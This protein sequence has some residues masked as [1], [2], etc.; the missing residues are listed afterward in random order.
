[1]WQNHRFLIGLIVGSISINLSELLWSQSQLLEQFVPWDNFDTPTQD[2][3]RGNNMEDP[4]LTKGEG[5]ETNKGY[6]DI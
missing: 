3:T 4:F 5:P 6:N 1:M 2:V